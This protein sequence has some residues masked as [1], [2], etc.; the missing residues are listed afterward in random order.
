MVKTLIFS[1]NENIAMHILR[2]LS[3]VRIRTCVM[4]ISKFHPIRLSRYCD[5]YV[6]YK[7]QDL[8]EDDNDIINNINNYCV[9]QK[10]DIVMPAGIEATLFV[11]EIRDRITTAKVFPLAK[12][13]TLKILNNKWNFGEL[14]N[15]NG[16][17]CPKTI[18]ITDM[19]QLESLVLE[20]PIIIKQLELESGKGVAKLNSYEELETYIYSK[21]EFSRLPLLIQEYIPGLDMGINVLAKNGK[22]IAWSIQ[23]YRSNTNITEFIKDLN[24]LNI[25]RQIVS[26]CNYTGVANIDMRFDDRDNSIKVTECNPRFWGSVDISLLSGVNFA[27]LGILLTNDSTSTE[28]INRNIN[29]KE[30]TYMKPKM[31]IY[32]TLK[33]MSLKDVNGHNL[34]FMHEIIF[35]PLSYGYMNIILLVARLKRLTIDTHKQL[36]IIFKKKNRQLYGT[37]L[38]RMART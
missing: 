11:S 17:S 25:G 23:R 9:Q 33:N 1:T 6:T 21:N 28:D 29:Y 8:L 12:L 7:L 5:N 22:I 19:G 2:C 3:D 37:K 34:F 18:L 15:K 26:C 36:D 31:F 32:E 27:Y 4:G 16:I 24:I 35:D 20:F 13:E 14:M 30:I 10:I 38:G